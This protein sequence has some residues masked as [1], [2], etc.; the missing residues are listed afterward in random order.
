[1]LQPAVATSFLSVPCMIINLVVNYR[2]IRSFLKKL[3]KIE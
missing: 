2:G 3:E 1:M